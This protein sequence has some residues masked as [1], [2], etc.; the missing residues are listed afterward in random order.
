MGP[1]ASS[2]N[3]PTTYG[4]SEVEMDERQEKVKETTDPDIHNPHYLIDSALTENIMSQPSF[5]ST[6]KTSKISLI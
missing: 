4:L 3:D 6:D 2:G 1:S 5:N